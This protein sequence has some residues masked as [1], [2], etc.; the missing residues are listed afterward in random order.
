M[1]Y[2]MKFRYLAICL[3]CMSFSLFGKDND[4]KDRFE[5]RYNE[6]IALIES[7]AVQIAGEAIVIDVDVKAILINKDEELTKENTRFETYVTFKMLDVYKGDY[8]KGD[9]IIARIHG[10][11]YIINGKEIR[12]FSFNEAHPFVDNG[13]QM[14]IGGILDENN[15]FRFVKGEVLQIPSTDKIIDHIYNQGINRKEF[16][17]FKKNTI[18][19]EVEFQEVY[20]QLKTDGKNLK[21][22]VKKIRKKF[23]K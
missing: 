12:K 15:Y 13:D 7:D 3:L 19:P 16:K 2:L 23:Q 8:K 1:E 21:K 11:K 10:G 14:I 17:V 18:D 5:K 20:I 4:I 22:M 6:V 9:K